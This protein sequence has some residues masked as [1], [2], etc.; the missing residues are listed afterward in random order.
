[1]ENH[2]ADQA[3]YFLSANCMVSWTILI[4]SV[5]LFAFLD[6]EDVER[7]AVGSGVLLVISGVTIITI[8]KPIPGLISELLPSIKMIPPFLFP[9]IKTVL[10]KAME[11]GW[12]IGLWTA[13]AGSVAAAVSFLIKNKE[14]D[15]QVKK[16]V[17]KKKRVRLILLAG[18][19]GLAVLA[20]VGGKLRFSTQ[21]TRSGQGGRLLT[22]RC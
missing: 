10:E 14:V 16:P 1:M 3:D 18:I 2:P 5:V 9:V 20:V 4:R 15:K 6:G 17:G 11:L 8:S 22:N 21:V 19:I 12:K 7:Q 13:G